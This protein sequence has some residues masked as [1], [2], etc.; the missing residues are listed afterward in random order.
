R[1][2]S[3]GKNG[4]FAIVELSP[5]DAGARLYIAQGFS[6]ARHA[7]SATVRQIGPIATL[8][9]TIYPP[10][11]DPIATAVVENLVVDDFQQFTVSDRETGDVLPYNL[12]VP[13]GYDPDESYP[14][15]L[16][17]HDAGATS[18]LADTTLVQG[19]GAVAWASPSD[20]AKHP[21]FVLA[22]Q[23]SAQ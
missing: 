19:L 6:A 12:F 5:D 13:T 21:A 16:F 22:P 10:S 18:P 1:K 3:K 2:G 8:A 4:R 7:A 20:R 9:G 17:M 23:Y 11:S 15:V 14:L